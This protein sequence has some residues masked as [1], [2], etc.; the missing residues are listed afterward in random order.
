MIEHTR[1]HRGGS[2]C[3]ML[4]LIKGKGSEGLRQLLHVA[5]GLCIFQLQPVYKSC[6]LIMLDEMFRVPPYR[7]ES[8]IKGFISKR[9]VTHC[10]LINT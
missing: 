5:I 7:L 4:W 6:L 1:L 10:F 2:D 3:D 8:N 9:C